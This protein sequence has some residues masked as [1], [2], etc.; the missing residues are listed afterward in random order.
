M[1]L[2]QAIYEIIR[3]NATALASFGTR[4]YPMTI[5][6]EPA[7]PA[8]VYQLDG[9]EPTF[10]QTQ[11]EQWDTCSVTLTVYADTYTLCETYADQLR[12]AISRYRGSA[13]SETVK[14]TNFISMSDG[15]ILAI[16]QS[17]AATTSIGIFTKRITCEIITSA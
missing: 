8:I 2:G 15:D 7:L 10:T 4:I 6:D 14:E 9:I 11:T 5:P 3:A 16:G 12:T 1:A 17:E 13:G